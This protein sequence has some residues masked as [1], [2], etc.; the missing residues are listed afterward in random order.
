MKVIIYEV[1][2]PTAIILRV[3]F[4]I[5]P[6]GH[7][8]LFQY[9]FLVN[10]ENKEFLSSKEVCKPELAADSHMSIAAKSVPSRIGLRIHNC[11]AVIPHLPSH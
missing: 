2:F 11:G 10:G 4:S 7:K 1:I 8:S 3:K 6:S 5:H 9:S